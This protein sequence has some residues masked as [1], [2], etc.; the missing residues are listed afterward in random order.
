MDNVEKRAFNVAYSPQQAKT[1][2]EEL[3]Y[4]IISSPEFVKK[5]SKQRVD[6]WQFVKLAEKSLQP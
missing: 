4:I 5:G 3:S 2:W 1:Q 6:F